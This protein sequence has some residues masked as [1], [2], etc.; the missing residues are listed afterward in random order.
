MI[1]VVDDF[2]VNPLEV[3]RTALKQKYTNNGELHNYPGIRSLNDTFP[4]GIKDY[5]LSKVRYYVGDPTLSGSDGPNF[6]SITKTYKESIF[7][8]DTFPYAL[9]VYLSLNPAPNSG[10][11]ICD[12]DHLPDRYDTPYIIRKTR[13]FY[14]DPSNLIKRLKYYRVMRKVNSWYNPMITVDNKFNRAV[15]FNSLNF[16]RAQ[17]YFGTSLADGR[18]TLIAWFGEEKMRKNFGDGTP[19]TKF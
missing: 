10:T 14:T 6:Q 5:C 17:N 7:H 12:S 8:R 4:E 3:R 2:F 11:E 18:L 19:A 1:H 15:I 13:E 9:I 16:H